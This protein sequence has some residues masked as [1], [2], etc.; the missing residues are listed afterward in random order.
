MSI[1]VNT[2]TSQ[3]ASSSSNEQPST[4]TESD[5]GMRAS[6]LNILRVVVG[7]S[8][9]LAEDQ[10]KRGVEIDGNEYQFDAVVRLAN[11]SVILA[12]ET[13]VHV[14]PAHLKNLKRDAERST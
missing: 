13:K 7:L 9:P 14:I 12:G 8:A 6:V 5:N 2:D 10:L 1:D 4:P 3:Y 11:G